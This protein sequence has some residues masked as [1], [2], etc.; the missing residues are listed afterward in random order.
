MI[1]SLNVT[2]S[3]HDKAD[4]WFILALSNNRSLNLKKTCL[5]IVFFVEIL[6]GNT[7]KHFQMPIICNTGRF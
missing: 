4:K 7:C 1:I 3:H 6:M 5:C 2:C